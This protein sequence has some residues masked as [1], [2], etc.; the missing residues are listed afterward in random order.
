[1]CK[2]WMGF[3]WNMRKIILIEINQESLTVELWQQNSLFSVTETYR[4]L[5]LLV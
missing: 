5:L 4:E 3:V 2:L 1:M